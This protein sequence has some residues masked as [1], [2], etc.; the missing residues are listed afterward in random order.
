MMEQG[1]DRQRMTEANIDF[2]SNSTSDEVSGL[3]P[4]QARATLERLEQVLAE[5]T[6]KTEETVESLIDEKDASILYE[7]LKSGLDSSADIELLSPE[8]GTEEVFTEDFIAKAK[9]ALERVLS[10]DDSS[11]TNSDN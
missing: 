1:P 2:E 10:E 6:P 5:D 11:E 8:E 7:E 9:E 3:S 4:E